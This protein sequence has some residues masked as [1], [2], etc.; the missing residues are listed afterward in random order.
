[1]FKIGLRAISSLGLLFVNIA[2]ANPDNGDN[3][4]ELLST[5]KENA[6]TGENGLPKD[7]IALMKAKEEL[8]L[9]GQENPDIVVTEII[10]NLGPPWT[11]NKRDW[12]YRIALVETLRDIG[13]AAKSAL[14]L[15][16]D[17]ANDKNERND[18]VKFQA[19]SA[20][21]AVSSDKPPK[22]NFFFAGSKE[23]SP[24]TFPAIDKESYESL[25]K[26]YGRDGLLDLTDNLAI[27][28][29]IKLAHLM[30]QDEDDTIA[31]IGAH[32]LIHHDREKE[33]IPFF[34][35]LFMSEGNEDLLNAI[36]YSLAHSDDDTLF[37]RIVHGVLEQVTAHIDDYQDDELERLLFDSSRKDLGEGSIKNKL[38]RLK[39]KLE[40][41]LSGNQP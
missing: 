25:K 4:N 11:Y 40:E 36:G 16:K 28:D 35:R 37:T 34:S 1:M 29:Q 15:L 27:E 6:G 33:T 41:E 12:A 19:E 23:Q 7:V 13:P 2:T 9:L 10:G 21:M 18:H 17:I 5:I 26:E 22:N 14:P 3:Y 39:E 31:Y 32:I 8:A 20:I 30:M 24:K 38:F